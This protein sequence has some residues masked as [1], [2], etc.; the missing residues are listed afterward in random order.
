MSYRD[1]G[2]EF[3]HY[4]A[5][6]REVSEKIDDFKHL[7]CLGNDYA[8]KM[9]ALDFFEWMKNNGTSTALEKLRQAI[10]FLGYADLLKYVKEVG[11]MCLVLG[12]TRKKLDA[13]KV[14]VRKA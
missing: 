6:H 9:A 2:L 3:R 4:V 12:D 13:S 1:K 10:T 5:L 14:K 11:R 7:A 8:D